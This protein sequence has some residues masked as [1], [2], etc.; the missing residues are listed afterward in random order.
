MTAQEQAFEVAQRFMQ[1]GEKEREAILSCFSESERK[2]FMD[3]IGY[4]RLFTDQKFYNA[5]R[6]AV[7]EQIL[8]EAQEA[9]L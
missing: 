2:V 9:N 1:G 5:V 4:Y 3:F 8:K 6:S 7:C